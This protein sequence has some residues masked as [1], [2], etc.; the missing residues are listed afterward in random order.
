M[1]SFFLFLFSSFFLFQK[2]FGNNTTSPFT[3]PFVCSPAWQ[4]RLEAVTQVMLFVGLLQKVTV[5]PHTPSQTSSTGWRDLSSKEMP[6]SEAWSVV[7]SSSH[8][9][10]ACCKEWK[11]E[12]E[13]QIGMCPCSTSTSKTPWRCRSEGK[14]T[15]RYTSGQSN[16]HKWLVPLKN[17]KCFGAWDTTCS[18]G[19][20]TINRLQET[21]AV[22]LYGLPWKEENG[23]SSN[24]TYIGNFW[25]TGWSAYGFF[26]VPRDHFQLI[27]TE[28]NCYWSSCQLLVFD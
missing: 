9:Q 3:H 6:E 7:P 27:W 4:W 1:S 16:Q 8:I 11:V 18:Q 15:S 2:P 20:H 12:W 14:W 10:W 5:K 21:G 23:P 19:Y 17:L 13:T 25:E 22:L 26:R 24:R 28:L